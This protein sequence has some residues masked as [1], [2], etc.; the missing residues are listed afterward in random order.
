[1]VP[2]IK[3]NFQSEIA[4]AKN[5]WVCDDCLNEKGVGLRDSQ[6][7]ILI[8]PAYEALRQGKNLESDSDLVEYYKLVLKKRSDV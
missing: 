2:T 6:S 4:Y 1:M 7:P 3:M 8:C 5:L